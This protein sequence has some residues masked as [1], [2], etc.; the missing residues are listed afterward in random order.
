MALSNHLISAQVFV[1]RRKEYLLGINERN[2]L[3]TV[4][5]QL[6]SCPWFPVTLDVTF[7]CRATIPKT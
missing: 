2:V 5:C 6:I 3:D 7:S 1:E 4:F